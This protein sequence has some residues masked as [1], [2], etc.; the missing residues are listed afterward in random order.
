MRNGPEHRQAA[1]RPTPHLPAIHLTALRVGVAVS[2]SLDWYWRLPPALRRAA[3]A[4]TRGHIERT[5]GTC[6][7][8]LT[9]AEARAA[10]RWARAEHA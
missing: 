10:Y 8:S 2:G 4:R 1:P 6:L 9:V 3:D 7:W 5:Y